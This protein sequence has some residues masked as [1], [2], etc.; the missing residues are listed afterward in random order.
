MKPSTEDILKAVEEINATNII[1]LPNNGN[2]ILA[3][4]QAK[5]LSDKNLMVLPTKTI[6]EGISALLEFNEELEVMDN[7]E[8]M[9]NAFE[10]INTA[11]VTFSVR[12]TTLDGKEIKKDDILGINDG[13]LILV[14]KNIEEVTLK[15]IDSTLTDDSELI[16]VFYGEDITEEEGKRI[17]DVLEERYSDFDIELIYGGQPIYYYLIAIE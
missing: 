15:L 5:E 6:P 16:T 11:Q 4:N 13:K 14:G 2:I 17:I 1:V 7:I 3:A 10:R 9:T 12:D 8:N